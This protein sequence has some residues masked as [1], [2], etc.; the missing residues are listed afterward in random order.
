HAV[1]RVS[2]RGLRRPPSSGNGNYS[3]PSRGNAFA[4]DSPENWG[5][6]REPAKRHTSTNTSIRASASI[7]AKTAHSRL[8]WPMV[9]SFRASRSMPHILGR[10]RALTRDHDN[11]RANPCWKNPSALFTPR[12]EGVLFGSLTIAQERRE[13]LAGVTPEGLQMVAAFLDDHRRQAEGRDPLTEPCEAFGA[14]LD[15]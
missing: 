2:G 4:I 14:D 1:L 12:S 15:G 5:L 13:E 6:R 8:E 7:P 11:Q 9:Q 10:H 3:M